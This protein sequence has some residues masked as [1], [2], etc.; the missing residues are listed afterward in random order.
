MTALVFRGFD[1]EAKS[2][3][4]NV[5]FVLE[6]FPKS[7]KSLLK[8]L[9]VR[10]CHCCTAFAGDGVM[11]SATIDVYK[12]YV[13]EFSVEEAAHLLNCIYP[14][15]VDIVS[16]VSAD[17]A[18]DDELHLGPAFLYVSSFIVEH[19]LGGNT[20]GTAYEHLSFILGIEIDESLA[21]KEAFLHFHSP[22]HSGLL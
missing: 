14:F 10:S 15:L 1:T 19:G 13:V 22:V 21:R 3:L 4:G 9:R 17:S 18:A 20:A 6:S 8:A 7:E 12:L 2:R 11:L 16:A 5:I